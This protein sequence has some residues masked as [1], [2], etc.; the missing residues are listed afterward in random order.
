MAKTVINL[1]VM[2]LE[3]KVAPGVIGSLNIA[4]N[5][6]SS[7]NVM[8]QGWIGNFNGFIEGAGTNLN[9][10]NAGLI[11]HMN[12]GTFNGAITNV[13]NTGMIWEGNFTTVGAM[14]NIQNMGAIGTL[15]LAGLGAVVNVN[16]MQGMINSVN[17][18]MSGS[19]FNL[20]N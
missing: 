10:A 7:V 6:G 15:N 14:T 8:N 1:D 20:L 12:V 4:A 2:Q 11:N 5:G 18:Q 13:L 19:L 16:N 17:A 3:E 9:V